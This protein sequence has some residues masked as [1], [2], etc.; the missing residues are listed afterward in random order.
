MRHLTWSRL[1]SM[2]FYET[3]ES[4]YEKTQMMHPLIELCPTYVYMLEEMSGY[5]T[6]FHLFIYLF[7]VRKI[8]CRK[9]Q[10]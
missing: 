9:L 7:N 5:S 2:C 6:F 1:Y 8:K 4:S 10:S 3:I